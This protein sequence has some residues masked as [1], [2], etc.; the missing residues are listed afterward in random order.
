MNGYLS[1]SALRFGQRQMF[2]IILFQC[3]FA[4]ALYGF[5]NGYKIQNISKSDTKHEKG[6]GIRTPKA[7]FEMWKI[8]II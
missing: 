3:G 8:H 2:V 7:Q 4:V 1:K 5:F 6:G